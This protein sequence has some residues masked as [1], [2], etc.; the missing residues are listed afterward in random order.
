[1]RRK[2]SLILNFERPDTTCTEYATFQMRKPMADLCTKYY[3]KKYDRQQTN[4][5]H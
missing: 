1:M 4:D 2:T 5:N 3:K